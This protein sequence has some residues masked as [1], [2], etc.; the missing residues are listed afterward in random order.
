MSEASLLLEGPRVS[1]RLG[2]PADIPA[3]I[4][5]Y[6]RNATHLEPWDP[7][8]P[9]DFYMGPYWERRIASDHDDWA[10]GR[11]MHLF[12]FER[13]APWRVIGCVNFNNVIQGVAWF[14]NLGYGLDGQ[15]E[16]HGLMREALDVA[17][18]Y[19]F[20]GP[21]NLHRVQANYMPHNRRSGGLLRRLGFVVEGYA[22][23]Y[24]FLNGRWEDHVL[25]SLTNPKWAPPGARG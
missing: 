16:G 2:T 14:C 8:R 23:D 17:L 4:E 9:V 12:V 7:R 20:D 21:L 10:H 18:A 25:T 6:Q 11:S 19:A 24:L 5:Y 1:L 13:E 3:I 22:R 15:K